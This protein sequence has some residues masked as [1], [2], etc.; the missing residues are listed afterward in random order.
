MPEGKHSV[1]LLTI[2]GKHGFTRPHWH[3]LM[4]D[5]VLPRIKWVYAVI[6]KTGI[7]FT[8]GELKHDPDAE[9]ELKELHDKSPSPESH[10]HAQ[11]FWEDPQKCSHL[12]SKIISVLEKECPEHYPENNEWKGW[13]QLKGSYSFMGT[14][15]EKDKDTM[16]VKLN[17]PEIAVIGKIFDNLIEAKEQSSEAQSKKRK[18]SVNAEYQ[19]MAEMYR[20]SM[21]LG[22]EIT[23]YTVLEWLNDMMFKKDKIRIGRD[24]RQ[25]AQKS[26]FLYCYLT[27]R[28][29]C[30]PDY[31][32]QFRVNNS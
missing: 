25:I 19:M 10:L 20:E 2:R 9:E 11:I 16:I 26:W 32:G 17:L 3:C 29:G 8:R 4:N 15:F 28:P 21:K 13:V 27:G 5:R 18:A 24:C 7:P 22:D 12:K 6:E 23:E 14:Y 1:M 31:Y 30:T